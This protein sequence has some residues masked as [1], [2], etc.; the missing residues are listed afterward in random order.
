MMEGIVKEVLIVKVMFYVYFLDKQ[1]I[2]KCVVEVMV[3]EMVEG[4]CVEF[5][6]EVVLL[7][8]V[9]VVF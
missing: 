5:N 1:S 9:I 3:Q 7:K 6:V 8:C 4:F 2:F